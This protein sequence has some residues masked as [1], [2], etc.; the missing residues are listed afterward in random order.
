MGG[1][2]EPEKLKAFLKKLFNAAG[3]NITVK[4]GKESGVLKVSGIG[5]T[6]RHIRSLL[7][8]RCHIVKCRITR[9]EVKTFVKQDFLNSLEYSQILQHPSIP[10]PPNAAYTPNKE[11]FCYL[12]TESGILSAYK[13]RYPLMY[14]DILRGPRLITVELIFKGAADESEYAKITQSLRRA[15]ESKT[16]RYAVDIDGIKNL[17]KNLPAGMVIAGKNTRNH[18][19]CD[20]AKDKAVA[21]VKSQGYILNSELINLFRYLKGKSAAQKASHFARGEAKWKEFRVGGKKAWGI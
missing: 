4:M 21:A 20:S 5:L 18:K 3:A 11:Y 9:L 15:L 16:Y 19:A 17:D 7:Y 8:R 1:I 12:Q 14:K 10:L 2:T 6:P 13:L